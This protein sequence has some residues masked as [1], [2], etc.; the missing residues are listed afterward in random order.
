MSIRNLKLSIKIPLIMLTL[1][2]LNAAIVSFVSIQSAKKSA[3]HLTEEKMVA[4]RD[5]VATSME[6]YLSSIEE[7]LRTNARSTEVL[8]ALRELTGAYQELSAV[9][10]TIYLQKKYIDENPNEVGKKQALDDAKDG[11]IYSSA[12]AKYHPWFRDLLEEREYYDIFLI[13]AQGDVVY[14]VFKERDFATNLLKGQWK[15]S[16]LGNLFRDIKKNPKSKTIVFYDFKPYAPSADVPAAFIGTPVLGEDGRFL[17]AMVFQMPIGRINHLTQV[18]KEVSETAEVHLIGE[19]FFLRN[20]PNLQ[21][22]EDPILKEKMELDA[23]KE[24]LAGKSGVMWGMDGT[25]KTLNAYQPLN[26]FGKKWVVMVDLFEE[27]A[28]APSRELQKNIGFA[29]VGILTIIGLLS[30]AY[31]RT[32]VKPIVALK[33]VMGRLANRDYSA[34]IPS[35]D[36]GDEMG[37][38]A[39]AVAVFKEN[40]L[41]VQKMEAEQIA[42]KQKAE[43]EKKEAMH[44]L[45]NDFDARTSGV[46]KSL[47]AAATEMQATAAQ[48]NSASS[49]TAAASQIV[50]SAATEADSNVQT[51]AAAAEELS[52]SSSEIARQISSVAQKSSRASEEAERTNKEV[53]ELNVLA[54]SIGEVIGAIKAIAEQTN[55]LALNATIEAA[56]AGEAGKGFAVVADEVKKLA[57]ETA[58]KTIEIDERVARIQSAI[59]RSVEAVQRIIADVRE[60]DHATGTVASAV[61]EQNAATAEIGRNVAE[62]STGTQQVAANIIEVQKNAEETGESASNLSGAATELAEISTTLQTEVSKFLQEIRGS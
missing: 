48:M 21:D 12:H 50:A 10:S 47:A 15:D 62:A 22:K 56:R 42:L 43:L 61:E 44:K 52:A 7:D 41:A 19:D 4:M 20:D 60:I 36:R 23:V 11:S 14:T 37:D 33:D 35:L 39:R 53:S 2:A 45:A 46:I 16:D 38:M 17:G 24:G 30:L 58:S 13:D 49:N 26:V 59:R 32:L 8:N 54:D 3:L 1:A 28:M 57:T 9:N 25:Q 55:L 51:V 18:H 29:A 5:G 31:A 27:E 6:S 34:D 40:G